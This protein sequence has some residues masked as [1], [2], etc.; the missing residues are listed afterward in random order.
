MMR[1]MEDECFIPNLSG[2]ILSLSL[3]LTTS[4]LM[5]HVLTACIIAGISALLTSCSPWAGLPDLLA[6]LKHAL[7]DCRRNNPALSTSPRQDHPFGLPPS[8]FGPP[9]GPKSL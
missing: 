6:R 4:A 8:D 1:D 7:H 2:L 9:W 5:N 3:A